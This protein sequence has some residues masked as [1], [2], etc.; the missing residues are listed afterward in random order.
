MAVVHDEVDDGDAATVKRRG[1]G[2]VHRAQRG[3]GAQ[4]VQAGE[5]RPQP[6]GADVER[7]APSHLLL[8]LRRIDTHASL[9]TDLRGVPPVKTALGR[10]LVAALGVPVW[11]AIPVKAALGWL[12]VA[13][14]SVPVWLAVHPSRGRSRWR[15]ASWPGLP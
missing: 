12:H 7:D 1:N 4:G 11:L 9:G 5:W 3:Y 2:T 14:R 13:A 8:F 10:L 6:D 15:P